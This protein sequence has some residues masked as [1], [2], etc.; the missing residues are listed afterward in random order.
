MEIL[1]GVRLKNATNVWHWVNTGP[2]LAIMGGALHGPVFF[3]GN[4]A[5]AVR[6]SACT[7]IHTNISCQE[8]Q[9]ID[10]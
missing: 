10:I 1:L 4:H 8:V 6:F 5:A 9:A 2:L 7:I 3:T